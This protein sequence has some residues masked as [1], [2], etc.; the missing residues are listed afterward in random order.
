VQ[1]GNRRGGVLNRRSVQLGNRRGMSLNRRRPQ[2]PAQAS[3]EEETVPCSSEIAG[4]PLET[5][6]A[7]WKTACEV[8]CSFQLGN[9]RG[10]V[11][12]TGDAFVPEP[13]WRL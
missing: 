11:S 7:A 3:L 12:E 5:V 6:S 10:G 9:R 13:W 2:S 1:L 4:M 8:L